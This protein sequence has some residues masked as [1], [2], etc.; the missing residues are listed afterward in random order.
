M[1]QSSAGRE[2]N[3]GRPGPV[4]TAG[5]ELVRLLHDV[6]DAQVKIAG[7][8]ESSSRELRDLTARCER[9]A[10]QIRRVAEALERALG[11]GRPEEPGGPTHDPAPG[12]RRRLWPRRRTVRVMRQRG[13]DQ[14]LPPAGEGGASHPA[15]DEGQ[16]QQGQWIAMELERLVMQ[17]EE[18]LERLS[19]K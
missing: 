4:E 6:A 14:G 8:V 12:A 19:R 15:G 3:E 2:A 10:E 1:S 13:R 17:A 18:L 5:K 9:A 16:D 7:L 11:P